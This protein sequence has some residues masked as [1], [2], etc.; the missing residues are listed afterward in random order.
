MPRFLRLAVLA[1]AALLLAGCQKD[2]TAYGLTSV[3]KVI[4]FTTRKPTS[5]KNTV[6]VSGLASGQGLAA[7][8]YRPSTDALYCITSDGFLCTLNPSSGAAAV[9]GTV[10]F[11]Q[12][13]G[14]GG[15]SVRL[16]NP[17][18]SFDPVV[19][20]LRVISTD[21]NLRVNP[22]TGALIQKATK[23]AFDGNDTNNGK[24]PQLAGIVYRNPAAGSA[25]AT[26]FALD[27]TTGSLLRIGDKDTGAAASADGGD[28]RTVGSAKLTFSTNGGFAIERVNSNV[29]AVLQPA[30]SGAA[31]YTVDLDTG[32]ASQIGNIGSGDQTLESLVIVP[33]N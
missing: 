16:S 10:P 27:S 17:V 15:N 1:V 20:E 29:Y 14:S 23:I 11:T 5:I 25:T 22:D 2:Y 26:L 13:L 30:G 31:L 3:G 7:M 12:L 6:T 32:V 28:L 19:D 9:V 8:A 21:Y 18:I 4:Q 33:S 24:T